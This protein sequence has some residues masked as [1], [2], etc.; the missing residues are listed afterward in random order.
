MQMENQE[1]SMNFGKI[2]QLCVD[3][4]IN[5]AIAKQ[6]GNPK[7]RLGISG[8]HISAKIVHVMTS[9]SGH[10]LTGKPVEYIRKYDMTS[11]DILCEDIRIFYDE[12]GWIPEKFLSPGK[13]TVH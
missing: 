2:A 5:H 4:E 12:M 11:I 1:N 3:S 10:H 9:P 13:E 6:N 8:N 7:A